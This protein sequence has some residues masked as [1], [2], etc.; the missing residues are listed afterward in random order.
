VKRGILVG[1]LLLVLGGAS[2][3][4]YFHDGSWS[5][6]TRTCSCPDQPVTCRC[7]LADQQGPGWYS[8]VLTKGKD[9]VPIVDCRQ[10]QGDYW[11]HVVQ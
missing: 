4:D 9:G 8:G 3:A 10:N 2:F 6:S 5:Y 11:C 1:C 7:W